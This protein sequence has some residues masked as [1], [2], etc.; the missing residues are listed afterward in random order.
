MTSAGLR[1]YVAA[2]RD[3]YHRASK[4]AKKHILDEFCAVTTFHRKSAIRCLGRD[5]KRPV[6]RRGRKK[7]Y[8]SDL[9][10]ALLLAWEATDRICSK[11]LAPFL[12]EVIPFLERDNGL[13]LSATAREQLF[14]I[15]A[16]TIDR[17][18]AQW[19]WR[20][21]RRSPSTTRS[22]SA[23]K[24]LIPIR[25][26]AERRTAEAGHVEVDLAA[27]CGTSSAGFYLNT[28][29]AVD[30][31][32]GWTECQAVWGKGQS[33]VGS[34][35]HRMRQ[36]LPFPLLGLNT[37]NGSEFINQ[38]LWR[39]C[40]QH[41]IVFTRSRAYKKND[42]AHVEQKNWSVV[43]R[44]VGYERYTSKAAYRQ[45]ENL[46]PLVRSY[47]NFFQPICK[48]IGTHR[49]GAKVHRQYDRAQSPYQ[50]LL[51]A[52]ALD[53]T[54]AQQLAELY[55]SLNPLTLRRQIDDALR[56]LWR[57]ASPDARAEKEHAALAEMDAKEGVSQPQ[58]QTPMV[59]PSSDASSTLG[60]T[61]I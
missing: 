47:V 29:V 15:S 44:L 28:L 40:Q 46:Y 36:Q 10:P 12:R 32:T 57:L 39:Y 35:V 53:E 60:N 22:V 17:L 59:T 3:R 21:R 14:G 24:T 6:V 13:Q 2:V 31:A 20:L 49:E 26:G 34:A 8:G 25:T 7:K 37:D 38:G 30:L 16:S 42:Q 43:R 19:R 11:R 51:A 61:F 23:L 52:G 4:S 5:A 27:H 18:L 48:L 9:L 56:D 58:F 55:Q 50:R 45:L 1:E 33:R 41:Q 54:K